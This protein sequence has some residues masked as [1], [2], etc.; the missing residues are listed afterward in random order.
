MNFSK[1]SRQLLISSHCAV[2][3]ML[4]N[5]YGL[6]IWSRSVYTKETSL[7]LCARWP[8][9]AQCSNLG[10]GNVK[11]K[12]CLGIKTK[13]KMCWNII[14]CQDN[15]NHFPLH[16]LLRNWGIIICF[17]TSF[18]PS[19]WLTS[20]ISTQSVMTLKWQLLVARSGISKNRLSL[21]PSQEQSVSLR[22]ALGRRAGF[23]TRQLTAE[24][25]G[26]SRLG[27]QGQLPRR[28]TRFSDAAL[29]RFGYAASRPKALSPPRAKLWPVLAWRS[30]TSPTARH[31][32]PSLL[33][34]LFF[35]AEHSVLSWV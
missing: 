14:V 18:F 33:V 10:L 26:G 2:F 31:R 6:C 35:I 34:P 22:R 15:K 7:F 24:A 5:E 21:Y 11:E 27:R 16:A 3:L 23:C 32:A 29:C 4:K 1:Q 28:D 17:N 9:T 13:Q 20:L 19:A 30:L 8:V 12:G 25:C